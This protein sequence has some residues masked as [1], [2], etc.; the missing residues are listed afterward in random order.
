MGYAPVLDQVATN[1]LD[2]ALKYVASGDRPTIKIG[3]FL[4]KPDAP[5]SD[6]TEPDATEPSAAEQPQVCWFFQDDGI[7]ISSE[8][9][10]RIFQP[11]SRLHGVE[12][13]PGSGFGLAIVQRGITRLGGTC[14]VK[15]STP[16]G[17]RFWIKLPAYLPIDPPIH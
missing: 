1:L 4:D 13:Y 9:Q 12:S 16:R 17:S 2:N 5:E 11:F 15:S 3:A 7:G 8:D 14:G 6:S 10:S